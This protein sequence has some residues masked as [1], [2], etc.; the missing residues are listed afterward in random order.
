M[1]THWG[2]LGGEVGFVPPPPPPPPPVLGGGVYVAGPVPL[3]TQN[4]PSNVVP[5]CPNGSPVQDDPPGQGLPLA[6]IGAFI[7]FGTQVACV[8]KH[9]A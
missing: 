6:H 5:G 7:S 3:G 4:L 1:L 9:D 2:A 8:P